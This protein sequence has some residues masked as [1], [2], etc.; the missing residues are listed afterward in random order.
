MRAGVIEEAPAFLF[1]PLFTVVRGKR[2]YEKA[3]Q[4]GQPPQSMRRIMAASTNAS[5]LAHWNLS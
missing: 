1:L 5:P 2:L 3:S 4:A